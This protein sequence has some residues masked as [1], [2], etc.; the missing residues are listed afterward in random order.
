M[1]PKAPIAL[2]VNEAKPPAWGK[3]ADSS[4]MLNTRQTY[5]VPIKSV[6]MASPQNPPDARPLFQPAKS[7]EI[8]APT[9]SAQS[10]IQPALRLSLRR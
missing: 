10:R 6:A 5:I 1:R 3:A 8:T 2:R 9:P 7:P 4:A